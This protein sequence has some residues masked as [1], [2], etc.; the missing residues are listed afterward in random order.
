MMYS[1]VSLFVAYLIVLILL[2][3]EISQNVESCISIAIRNSCQLFL[4]ILS[5]LYFL[6]I[7]H[8]STFLNF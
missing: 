3:I 6:F 8:L 4:Q 2:G 1:D 5:S 7:F